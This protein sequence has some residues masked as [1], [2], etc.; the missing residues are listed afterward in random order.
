MQVNLSRTE[1]MA[2]EIGPIIKAE[3]KKCQLHL[4]DFR[5]LGTL[6]KQNPHHNGVDYIESRFYN[7]EENIIFQATFV[8]EQQ[9][10]LWELRETVLDTFILE[11][12]DDN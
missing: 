7:S 4:S 6:Y 9:Q 11:D 2:H 3:A 5:H 12:D 8:D 10:D 1:V